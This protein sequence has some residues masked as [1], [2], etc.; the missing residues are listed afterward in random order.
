[1]PETLLSLSNVKLYGR[2]LVDVDLDETG[3]STPLGDNAFLHKQIAKDA[4]VAPSTQKPRLAR[5]FA[6]TFEGSF[7]NLPRPAI[8]LVHGRGRAVDFGAPATH[9]P[10]PMDQTGLV[11]RDVLWEQ[12]VRYWEYDKNDVMLRLDPCSG[13]LN[14]ILIEATF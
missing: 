4:S 10:S 3:L 6:F 5:I 8:F 1:M 9:G 14:D 7:Y 11:A 12:D 2:P 13:T